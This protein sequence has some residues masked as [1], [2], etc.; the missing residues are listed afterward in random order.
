MRDL[1]Q[2]AE[3]IKVITEYRQ[4][5]LNE[6]DITP[7]DLA[8]HHQLTAIRNIEHRVRILACGGLKVIEGGKE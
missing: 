5:L 6:L 1:L 7:A 4:S 2:R 8:I 3:V